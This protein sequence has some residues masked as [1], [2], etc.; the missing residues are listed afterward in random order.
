MNDAEK[1]VAFDKPFDA[2]TNV[3]S[4]GAPQELGQIDEGAA[5]NEQLH[6][7]LKARQISMIALGG[8]IGTGLVIGSGSGL[9]KGGP[10]GLLLAYIVSP[11]A[12]LF[13]HVKRPLSFPPSDRFPFGALV[14]SP[15]SLVSRV[16]I[17][18]PYQIMG[19]ACFGVMT[20]L[21]EMATFLPHN[22]G[23]GGYASRF[24][25]PSM[26][27]AL[28]AWIT[29][30]LVIIVG[31]NLLGIKVFG[32]V[33]FW[34]SFLKIIVLVGLI[35]L[36][37]IIDL[38]GVAGVERIGYWRDQPFSHYIFQNNTGVFLG[39]WSCMV[40]AL[41]AYIGEAR[42]P[43]KTI[44]ATIRRTFFRLAFFYVFSIFVVGLIIKAND[45]GLLAANKKSTGA[46][47]SPFVLA[48]ERAN[49]K[50]LPEYVHKSLLGFVRTLTFITALVSSTP[51]SFSSACRRPTV[52]STCQSR[53][54]Q[55]PC[56]FSLTHT[57][58]HSGTRTLYALAAQG[59]APRIFMRTNRHGMPYVSLALCSL[60]CCI[61]YLNVSSG[62]KKV[63]GYFTALV[64][65]FG[66][67]LCPSPS[68]AS[69]LPPHTAHALGAPPQALTWMSIL[70]SHIRFMQALKA[71]GLS[72]DELP[73]KAPFQPYM[74][75]TALV[76]V[77]IVT[78]FKGFDSF[79]PKFN[80]ATFITSYLGIP[81]YC[82]LYLGHK[83]WYK[84][85]VL[86]PDEVDL[87]SGR[88][89]F[90]EDEAAW[91]EEEEAAGKKPLWKRIWEGA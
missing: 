1:D 16:L 61:A 45:P 32:E 58:R 70:W 77:A 4:R 44:P 27:F 40:T 56:R 8:S 7:G 23:F 76:I 15:F 39:V 84:T 22:K 11:R 75:Y 43:R 53:S 10:V 90:D 2:T 63:F 59:Q 34:A 17:T 19:F 69:S 60:V 65:I 83:F 85:K 33:E 36:G 52:T 48:I 73:W 50:I 25:D 51:R 41:F 47:A 79:T 87:V 30:Y 21:G 49:I 6:R 14:W 67:R 12:S 24:V 37:I 91:K 42:N 31:L 28:G 82:V 13:F 57:L 5:E 81:I 68:L 78:L 20:S 89:E 38:G 55:L 72:R 18:F 9:A 66:V 64:T 62:S 74:A 71:Q 26:G 3:I 88:R 29:I 80:H 46:A 86:K 35:L 54:R